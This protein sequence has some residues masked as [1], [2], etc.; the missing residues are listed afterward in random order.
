[1]TPK[2]ARAKS[3]NADQ[4]LCNI[5]PGTK[6][7]RD[8][9]RTGKRHVEMIGYIWIPACARRGDPERLWWRALGEDENN[10][11]A[12]CYEGRDGQEIKDPSPPSIWRHKSAHQNSN[13]NLAHCDGHDTERLGNPIELCG[14]LELRRAQVC[15]MAS[16]AF[17]RIKREEYGEGYCEGLDLQSQIFSDAGSSLGFTCHGEKYDP[18]IPPQ[19]LCNPYS[20]IQS[21]SNRNQRQ[22]AP[23]P[24]HNQQLM[25]SVMI[26]FWRRRRRKSSHYRW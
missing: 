4:P 9:I 6:A 12:G 16:T 18:I 19:I 2:T 21:E 10:N 8:L 26:S 25:S 15:N 22:R 5:S 14:L 20:R 13:R 7:V 11:Y 1:M 24:C 17:G 23:K 3:T